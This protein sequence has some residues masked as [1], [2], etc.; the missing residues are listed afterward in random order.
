MTTK[1]FLT[2]I[3]NRLV[4]VYGENP[5]LDYMIRLKTIIDSI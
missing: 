4:N 3:Y 2:W 1:E 5:N